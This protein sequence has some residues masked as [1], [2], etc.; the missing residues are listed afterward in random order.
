MAN[1]KACLVLY[2]DQVNIFLKLKRCHHL[3]ISITLFQVIN[4]NKI[5]NKISVPDPK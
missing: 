1:G 4:K 5:S 3:I 2:A